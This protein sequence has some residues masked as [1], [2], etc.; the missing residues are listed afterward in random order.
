[1]R[2][3]NAAPESCETHGTARDS[4]AWQHP[5]RNAQIFIPHR[6][7]G[8]LANEAL[9]HLKAKTP[10]EV[11]GILWGKQVLD[12]AEPATV[13]TDAQLVPAESGLYNVSPQDGMRLVR[14]LNAPRT[15]SGLVPVGYFR[16]HI[17]DGLALSAEDQRFIAENIRDPNAVFLLI[18]PFEIGICMGAFFFWQ[19]GRLQTDAS[20]LEVP[21]LTTNDDGSEDPPRADV[22]SR[23]APVIPI[24]PRAEEPAPQPVIPA[25]APPLQ[26]STPPAHHDETVLPAPSA[27]SVPQ[28]EGRRFSPLAA[29]GLAALVLLVISGI[30]AGVSLLRS[31]FFVSSNAGVGLRVSRLDSGQLDLSWNRDAPELQKA[32]SAKLA[33]SDGALH[34]ELDIDSA[35]LHLGRLIYFPQGSDVQFRLQVLL[36]GQHS[37]TES[38]RVIAPAIRQPGSIAGSNGSALPAKSSGQRPGNSAPPRRFRSPELVAGRA[39]FPAPQASHAIPLPDIRL[40]AQNDPPPPAALAALPKPPASATPPPVPAPEHASAS[41]KSAPVST[42]VPP[43]PVR[44]VMPDLRQLGAWVI[45]APTEIAVSVRIDETG[46]VSEA[47]PVVTA[48]TPNRLLASAALNA[49]RQWKFTPGMMRGKPV[50]T[51]HTI[52]F[53][54]RPQAH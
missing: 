47:T 51:D 45:S 25:P 34:Q 10:S 42:F 11:G 50:A 27:V 28:A 18:R 52:V 22:H 1:M 21:F 20:D 3:E 54:F 35:Q 44:E 43:H 8:M 23:P 12:P 39:Q 26:P 38:V 31:H 37:I 24:P 30:S 29:I 40:T 32:R 2:Y 17:R 36:D 5:L 7:M 16:S 41:L 6:T 9:R 33:I 13:I 15:P 46:T 53:E 48:K 14:A 19:D 49:A 4:I